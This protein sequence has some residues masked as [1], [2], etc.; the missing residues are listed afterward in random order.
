V[1][2]ANSE[3][4]EA[5]PGRPARWKVARLAGLCGL[6]YAGSLLLAAPYLV[7]SLRH[8]QGALARPQPAYSLPLVRLILPAS[9]Y[10]FGFGPLINYS[11]RI[12]DDGMENYVGIPLIVIMLVLAVSAWRN[13]ISLLLLAVFLFVIA[14][15]AGPNMVV[16]SV[17]HTHPLPW[18]GLW[19]LPIA[20]AAEPSRFIV[21]GVLAL[22]LALALWLAAPSTSWLLRGARWSLGLRRR[23]G[24]STATPGPRASARSSWS[25][26]GPHRGW[27]WASLACAAP[28]RAA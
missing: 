28:R 9:H 25:R 21:F 2:V 5:E 24:C 17:R 13:R 6:A 10:M 7:Y 16:T 8:Y 27:T 1:D 22:A 14:L 19:N 26:R 23:S 11:N 20:R 18:A 4:L 15:A 12:G 3:V